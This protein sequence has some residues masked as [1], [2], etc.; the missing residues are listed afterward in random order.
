MVRMGNSLS[1]A[2][3]GGKGYLASGL[4]EGMRKNA[5]HEG[6]FRVFRQG[7]DIPEATDVRFS[8]LKLSGG[9]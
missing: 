8:D 7:P 3:G 1:Q 9:C 2:Q 5:L 6:A 4:H